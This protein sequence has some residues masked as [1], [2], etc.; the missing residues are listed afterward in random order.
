MRILMHCLSSRVR[1]GWKCP[2]FE[3]ATFDLLP[4][5]SADRFRLHARY[6]CRQ[7]RRVGLFDRLDAAE[8]F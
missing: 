8:M 4:E 7:G 6:N 5:V 1:K 2:V 3:S